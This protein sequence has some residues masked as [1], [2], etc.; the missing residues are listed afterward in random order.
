MENIG[1]LSVLLAFC[2]AVFSIAAALAGKYA[3]RPFL[4]VSAERA[5]YAVW[6]LL[7]VASG[8]LITLLIQGDYRIAYVAAHTD[9]AMPAIYK[10]TA[11]WGG[12]QGSLLFWSWLLSTYSAVAVYTNRRKFRDMMPLVVAIM[13]ATLA[14]FVGMVT[15]VASPFQVLMAGRGIIDIGDG[16]GLSPLLQWW[17]MAIHPPFLY[18]GYVGCTVPFAFAMASLI[19]HQPGEGWIHTT[20]R[21]A[22]V[23]WLFQ[24]TGVSLGMY[25]AYTVLGWGGYW[26]WDPVENASLM[27]WITATAFLHSVMMQEKKGMMKVWNMVLVSA[28]FLLSILGTTLTRTGLVASVHAFAQSP[29]KPY[30]TTF[31]ITAVALTVFAIVKNLP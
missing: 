10:F 20:R 14:F 15:F 25:W 1:A 17:T 6:A 18:L 24:S 7:T 11:W 31:L 13:M 16:N 26:V 9:K 3:R 28:T 4:T 12:Q 29:V 22:I 2:L 19:T 30:F 5:V 8:I 21:W 23:T 27:P